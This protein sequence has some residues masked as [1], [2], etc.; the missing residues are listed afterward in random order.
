M[1]F[2]FEPAEGAGDAE[3]DLGAATRVATQLASNLIRVC[4]DH[5]SEGTIWP[6]DAA[7]RPEGKAGP[8]GT[9]AGEPPR[10]LR[11]LGQDLGVPGAAQGAAGRR[12]PRARAGVRR[13][14]L[15]DG[16]DGRGAG[17]RSSRT[18]RRCGAAS[19]DQIPPREADRQLKLGSGGLRDVEFAVQLLQLV[20]GRADEQIRPPDDPQRAGRADPRRVRRPRGRR[21]AARGVLLPAHARAPDPALPAA[22]HPRRALRRGVAAPA[23]PEHGARQGP[24]RGRWTRCGSTTA[25]RSAGCTRSSSTG[26]CSTAVARLPGTEARLS[27]EAA[28]ERLAALGYLDPKAALR[29]LEALTSGVS[30][31]ANI[32]RTLLP[33]MLEWFADAPDPDAGLFGFRRISESLGD[34]PWY[35][36]TL[37]DEGEVAERLARLLATVALRHQPA[38]ARAAGRADA[39]GGPGAAVGRG[40]HRGDARLRRGDRSTP[41]R[42]SRAVRAI[43]RRELFRIAPVTCSASSTSPTWVRRCR[44]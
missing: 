15:A 7:L 35:L 1:I 18:P 33:A 13:H 11:A 9:D 42:R 24:G 8:A 6:V 43:R 5:T 39:G 30:R 20:H 36:K 32:Q 16:V 38:R 31:S 19:I 4:S 37:R 2:V 17:G 25:A 14:R 40:P 22:A 34:S 21:G 10:L 41:R 28:E 26:R 23:R 29:H 3:P 27:L 12:R 44:G